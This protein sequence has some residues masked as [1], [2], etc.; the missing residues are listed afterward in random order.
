MIDKRVINFF[1]VIRFIDA[2]VGV[3]RNWLFG[4]VLFVQFYVNFSIIVGQVQRVIAGPLTNATGK[5]AK[6]QTLKVKH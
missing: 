4:A 6:I 3:E 2:I 1:I 5:G